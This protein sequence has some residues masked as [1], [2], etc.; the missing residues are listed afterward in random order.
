MM[1]NYWRLSNSNI[2]QLMDAFN[3]GTAAFKNWITADGSAGISGEAGFKHK[4]DVITFLLH[5]TD[6]AGQNRLMV[7]ND[8][9][10]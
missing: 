2:K 1:S 7:G 3:G 6:E 10:L 4:R 8:F 9:K 5:L